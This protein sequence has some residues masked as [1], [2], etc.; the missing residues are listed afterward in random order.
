M[1]TIKLIKYFKEGPHVS[2]ET[3]ISCPSYEKS[4]FASGTVSLMVKQGNMSVEYKISQSFETTDHYQTCYIENA[5]GK[6][7][8]K[9]HFD[10]IEDSSTNK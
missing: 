8:D 1:F 6:T 5:A 3:I 2:T 9:I 7:I 4:S 10:S